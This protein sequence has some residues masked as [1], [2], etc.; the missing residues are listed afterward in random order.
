MVSK[1]AALPELHWTI[2]QTTLGDAL[3]AVSGVGVCSLSFGL[4]QSQLQARF[5][6]A[7]LVE[8][9]AHVLALLDQVIAAI[10]AP[11]PA[12][13]DI[14]LDL[15]GTEFQMRV[16]DELRRI[17]LGETR[18]YGALA[19]A[20]ECPSASRAVGGANGANRVAVLVPCHRVIGANGSLGGYAWGLKIKA[21]LLRRESHANAGVCGRLI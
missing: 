3:I 6:G 21:E 9:G 4:D 17:P 19:A 16:W 15:A 20:L 8:R 11:S 14:P 1:S 13:L 7:R 12:M 5:P 2:V 10:E 18:S